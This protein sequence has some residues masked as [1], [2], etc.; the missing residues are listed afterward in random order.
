MSPTLHQVIEDGPQQDSPKW[1]P[2]A[3]LNYAENILVRSDDS[4]AC[5]VVREHGYRRHYTYRELRQSVQ[6]MASA[7]RANGVQTGDRV[8]GENL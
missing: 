2:G 1:F 3:R 4:I 6:R 7:M 5:T 8:A